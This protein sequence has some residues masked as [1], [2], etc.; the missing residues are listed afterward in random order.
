M[1]FT[2]K[3]LSASG[4]HETIKRCFKRISHGDHPNSIF[5]TQDCLMSGLAVF[6][7]KFPSLLQFEKELGS[8]ATIRRNLRTLYGVKNAPSDT[9]LRERLDRVSINQ[10]RE[11]FKKVFS[12]LQRGKA[13]ERYRY[14]D[15]HHIISIDGTGQYSSNTVH[16]ENCCSKTNKKSGEITYY[17]HMLGASLV[18]P[19]QK[20]VI[21]LAPEPI[22]K[23]DGDTKND[24]ERNASKR[25]LTDLR[26]EHPHLKILIVEDSL[27]S[28]YPH[29][30][31]I[32]S[33]KMN[34]VIGVKPGDHK[35]LFQWISDLKANEYEMTDEAG[36]KHQFSYYH[37]VPLN[38]AHHDYR[39]S[40]IEYR[41]T[42]KS[43]KTQKFSWVTSIKPTDDNVY[44]LMRAGR[45]RWKIENET[46]N[47]LKNQGYNFEHNYGHGNKNLCSVMTMLM[48]LA[49]LADQ[50]QEL[51]CKLYR[52]VREKLRT[53]YALF[54]NVRVLIKHFVWDDW[55]T[56]YEKLS[57]R[58]GDPP[59]KAVKEIHAY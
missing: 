44:D 17:H 16:C 20:V 19:D 28:N 7:L 2:R 36:T 6:G 35:Y 41:E 50:A 56:L 5:S 47:T 55:V 46:F 26:R 3:F 54:E 32:D 53:W 13:L 27:A 18:H 22:V 23:G 51:C 15:G 1:G 58:D 33:L 21:P 10:I 4:L 42:K 12:H 8:E 30:S 24:C 59:P 49:F 40:V 38:D 11:P 14:L 43:G 45:S 9:Q 29:L 52:K 31:L 48:M 57:W 37:N 25:L 39:V 34:Y